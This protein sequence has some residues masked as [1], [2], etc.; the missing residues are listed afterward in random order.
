MSAASAFADELFNTTESSLGGGS[1]QVFTES[2]PVEVEEKPSE[3]FIYD[4][5]VTVESRNLF[6][7]IA[8]AVTT[9]ESQVSIL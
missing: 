2:T 6:E 5:D 7:V 1:P 3:E 9:Y 8:A 4:F